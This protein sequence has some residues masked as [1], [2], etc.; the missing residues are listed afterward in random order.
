MSQMLCR[1][2]DSESASQNTQSSEIA[3]VQHLQ[4]DIRGELEFN[5]THEKAYGRTAQRGRQAEFVFGM[6]QR[7]QMGQFAVEAHETP[8]GPSYF[9][10]FILSQILCRGQIAEHPHE[11]AHRRKTV[12]M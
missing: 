2:E 8:H 6:R 3:R 9:N 12:P 4:H 1:K 10:L 5:E 7:I 11:V